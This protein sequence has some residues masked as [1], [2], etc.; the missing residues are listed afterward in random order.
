[1]SKRGRD[2]PANALSL[3]VNEKMITR[4]R[5]LPEADGRQGGPARY[6]VLGSMLVRGAA[7]GRDGHR[8]RS[9]GALPTA[10]QQSKVA[11]QGGQQ[12]LHELL[13]GEDFIRRSIE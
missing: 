8:Q 4:Q 13:V 2:L 10:R 6:F 7:E 9:L 5:H 11:A 12:K 3:W 1:M